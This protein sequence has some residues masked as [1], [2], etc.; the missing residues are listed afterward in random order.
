MRTNMEPGVM[1]GPGRDLFSVPSH[2]CSDGLDL[3]D[4]ESRM[5]M[6]LL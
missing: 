4:N 5:S 6:K 3:T 2:C 1:D